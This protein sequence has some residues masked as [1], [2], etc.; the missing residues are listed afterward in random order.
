[1]KVSGLIILFSDFGQSGPYVGHMN[2]QLI[3]HAPTV[4]VVHLM[5]DVPAF[6]VKAGAYLLHSFTNDI[7]G[8]VVFCCVVDPG[9]GGQR[10]PIVAKLDDRLFVG[11][12]NGLF[13]IICR[14]A[15][16]PVEVWEILWQPEK[17]SSSFH[18]RDIFAVIAARLAMGLEMNGN[19]DFKPML[20][21][22]TRFQQ[23]PENL[24]EVVY[25][26]GFGNIMLGVF[27]RS[28]QNFNVLKIRDTEIK[29][30]RTFSDVS[31]GEIFWYEN[32][33]GL[34]EIA[35]NGGAAVD[36]L[37]VSIGTAVKSVP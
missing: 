7:S 3:R 12:D 20:T 22:L 11:P 1:M 34:V 5:H 8:N 16:K 32:A 26:D 36:I 10:L 30:A 29:F 23:W 28:I 27:A 19:P 17:L 15:A 18:G 37:Q 25:I 21:G 13:E 31:F 35:V 6:D 9:V 4:P 2:A 14:H 24:F 33:Y